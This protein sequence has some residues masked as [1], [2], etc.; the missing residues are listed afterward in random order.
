MRARFIGDP[1]RGGEGPSLLPFMGVTFVKGEW[2]GD[3][4]SPL[5]NKVRNNSHFETTEYDTLE[6]EP[7]AELVKASQTGPLDQD[8]DGK[9]G[10]ANE[11]SEAVL[12]LR[13]ELDALEIKWDGRWGEKK[14]RD[15]RDA[16]WTGSQEPEAGDEE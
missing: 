16:A 3:L 12:A 15:A 14:L 5:A 11:P 7:A 8:G 6:V 1:R 4:P 9:R 13:A 2:V 10:G